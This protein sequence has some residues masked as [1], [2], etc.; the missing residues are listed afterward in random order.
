MK[1]LI[2]IEEMVLNRHWQ[3]KMYLFFLRRHPALITYIFGII[4]TWF[5]NELHLINAEKYN[6]KT[7]RYL[8]KVN[9]REEE[10]S[11]FWKR[12]PFKEHW[13]SELGNEVWTTKLPVMLFASYLKEQHIELK[14]FETLEMRPEYYFP[15]VYR[16][17]IY[18]SPKKLFLKK[19]LHI[20]WTISVLTVMGI[21]IGVV[22]LYF[23]AS[24]FIMPMFLSYFKIPGLA[25]LNIVPVVILIYFLYFLF[26]RVYVSFFV[27]SF[28]A[29]GLS[30]VNYYKLMFR[31]DPLLAS[32]FIF[33]NESV[34]MAGKY[35][36]HLNYKIILVFITVGLGILFAI[37][38][39]DG[40]ISKK[41]YRVT[42]ML[43]TLF[44]SVFLFNHVYASATYVKQTENFEHVNRWST[45]QVY[46]SRGFVYPFILSSFSSIEKAPKGYSKKEAKAILNEFTY[47]NIPET[48]KVNVIGIMLEAFDDFSKYDQI[49]FEKN[50]YEIWDALKAESFSGELVTNIFAGGTIDTERSFMTGYTKLPNF[51]REVPSYVRYFAEQ[52]YYVEGSHPGYDWFYNRKNVNDYLGFTQ[53]HFFENYYKD[54]TGYI[55][56][57][58]LFF[59]ELI[60]LFD[61]NESRN[62]PYF[63]FNVTYQNHGPYSTE[64]R[65]DEV[66]LKDQG[67]SAENYNILNNYLAG[68]NDT[69]VQLKKMIDEL[70]SREEPVVVIV[71]GD[72]N[73]WL[74]D[75]NSVYTMLNINLD[76]NTDEGFYNYY[77]T[78]YII[79]GNDAAK[80]AL[81]NE[82][83][84]DGP[85]I[86]P[87]YLMNTFFELAGLKGN[88]YM[89]LSTKV[90]EHVD[91]I[92]TTDRYREDH[93][94]TDVLSEENQKLLDQYERVQF[95]LKN[96]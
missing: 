93:V 48:K 20:G 25:L 91:I 39:T 4:W 77:D 18:D 76:M 71:F 54:L 72:H 59:P 88:E 6:Q 32:D 16:Q 1:K 3:R 35:P 14:A 30:L 80:K 58:E 17:K 85:Q 78:P 89:Q 82:L 37:Y 61:E 9:N 22:C 79:W 27:S 12:Y 84:G 21:G 43:A 13:F 69:Q 40:R 24:Y 94:L 60:K 52:G 51:R 49:Q 67:Y 8:E 28:I 29:I 73:P 15:L 41:R 36:I 2:M 57:D 47:E 46:I 33:F 86:G 53:Y 75:N 5:L 74:G 26:N 45:T 34:N 70:R 92:H 55:V 23:G 10:L 87:Y 65:T 81:G 11:L 96:E 50:P 90:M 44:L 7:W 66:F 83:V 42:G 62:M 56:K 19:C 63:S 68:I 38:L 95:Y 31:N 64:S